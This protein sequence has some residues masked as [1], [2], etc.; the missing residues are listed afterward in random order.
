MKKLLLIISFFLLVSSNSQ[1]SLMIY[2]IKAE[3]SKK[4]R[5]K[6][7]R[8]TNISGKEKK[9]RLSFQHL[10]PKKDGSYEEIKTAKEED[11]FIDNIV[12]FSPKIISLKPG[13][14]QIVRLL[15]RNNKDIDHGEYRS[16][17]LLSEEIPPQTIKSERK[18]KRTYNHPDYCYNI[19]FYTC[20]SNGRNSNR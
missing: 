13:K 12:I 11:K 16:H 8:I 4:D 17:L 2:P 3:L 9:Y 5:Q 1:A 20:Y 14:S 6:T 7:V 19:L 10:R 18:I 15:Y